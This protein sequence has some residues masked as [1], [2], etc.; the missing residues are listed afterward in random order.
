MTTSQVQTEIACAVCGQGM[1]GK[2]GVSDAKGRRVCGDCIEAARQLVARRESRKRQVDALKKSESELS[3]V[4]HDNSAVLSMS[5]DEV[6]ALARFACAN[7]GRVIPI[8]GTGCEA[9][10][11]GTSLGVPSRRRH[12]FRLNFGVAT[13]QSSSLFPQLDSRIVMWS[14]TGLVVLGALT[15]L[16]AL[17]VGW[18]WEGAVVITLGLTL[19]ALAL[20]G[21]ARRHAPASFIPH[22]LGAAAAIGLLSRGISGPTS[23]SLGVW[24]IAG[25]PALGMQC[26]TLATASDDWLVRRAIA[27]SMIAQGGMITI[28]IIRVAQVA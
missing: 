9:C 21:F 27:A 24:L 4:E 19:A 10:G 8:A 1:S 7:C 16:V 17:L 26:W 14:G 25:L 22:C 23:Q 15:P 11:F 3:R 5:E 12:R 6:L 13:S 18:M 2:A 28:A 20:L